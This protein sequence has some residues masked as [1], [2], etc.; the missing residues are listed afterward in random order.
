MQIIVETKPQP[1]DMS[2]IVQGLLAYDASKADG[3]TV[4]Y[5]VVTLR[6]DQNTVV[7]GIVGA[8]Y[9]GW[10]HI[11]TVWIKDDFRGQGHGQALLAAAE[12]EAIHRGAHSVCLESLTFQAVTFYEKLGYTRF[13]ELPNYPGTEK[14]VYLSKKLT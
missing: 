6:D 5:L 13:A 3:E 11:N 9:L 12:A 2:T 8:T 4:K 10:L 1:A 7:G 14:K